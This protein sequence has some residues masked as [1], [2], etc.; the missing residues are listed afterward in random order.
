MGDVKTLAEFL[1]NHGPVGIF[2]PVA[3][4]RVMVWTASEKLPA[5]VSLVAYTNEPPDGLLWGWAD[6]DDP[7]GENWTLITFSLGLGDPLADLT[8]GDVPRDARKWPYEWLK[9]NAEEV[10]AAA[11]RIARFRHQEKLRQTTKLMEGATDLLTAFG[12]GRADE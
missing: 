3:P 8:W 10:I 1:A 6:A 2:Q 11:R 4:F 7:R 12:P 5:V 9:A